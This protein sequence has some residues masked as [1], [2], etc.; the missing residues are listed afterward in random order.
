MSEFAVNSNKIC[1]P[2]FLGGGGGEGRGIEIERGNIILPQSQSGHS[3]QSECLEEASSSKKYFVTF[4]QSFCFPVK[5]IQTIKASDTLEHQP[6]VWPVPYACAQPYHL[7]SGIP[8]LI[9]EETEPSIRHIQVL[10]PKMELHCTFSLMLGEISI[11]FV[12]FHYA[13]NKII[14]LGMRRIKL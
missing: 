3:S 8:W 10:L 9:S 1:F 5:I 14:W 7:G 4:T 11:L 6:T 12:H 2:F 13:F